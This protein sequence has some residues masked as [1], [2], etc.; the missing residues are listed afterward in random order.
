MQLENLTLLTADGVKNRCQGFGFRPMAA[1]FHPVS[2]SAF[3]ST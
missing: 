2:S 3:L 1:V